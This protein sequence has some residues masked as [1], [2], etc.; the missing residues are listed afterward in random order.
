MRKIYVVV[1]VSLLVPVGAM[2]QSENPKATV[3]G[4][5]SYLRNG[6]QGANGFDG[7]ATFNFN[8][9]F[10]V[11]ADLAGNYRTV[12]SFAPTSFISTSATEHLYTYLFGPTIT[13]PFGNSSVFAHALFGAARASSGAGVSLPIIG[14]LS[15][16]IASASAFAMA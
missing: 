7:Q 10:G 2:C 9:Y 5:Y 4:G 8:H 13:A 12:A 3:F 15:T 6:G 14:G 16:G 1:L 11:T